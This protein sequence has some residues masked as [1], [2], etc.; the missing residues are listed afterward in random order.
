M[1]F[2]TFVQNLIQEKSGIRPEDE[3]SLFKFLSEID[4]QSRI[5]IMEKSHQTFLNFKADKTI[6]KNHFPALKYAALLKSMKSGM[7][8]TTKQTMDLKVLANLERKKIKK[9][10]RTHK[11]IRERYFLEIQNLRQSGKSW[12]FICEYLK[13]AHRF[14]VSHTYLIKIFQEELDRG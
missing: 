5:E 12:L 10:T 13:K 14:K 3:A 6:P 1:K 11:L 8:K 9:E 7:R 4:A 2:D